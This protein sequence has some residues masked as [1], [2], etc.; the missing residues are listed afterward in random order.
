M[1]WSRKRIAVGLVA[2]I[3][4][5]LLALNVTGI[6]P[7]PNG[8]LGNHQ[9]AV[10]DG[11]GASTLNYEPQTTAIYLTA[12]VENTGP[13]PA[14]V[15]RV[16]PTGVTVPG[17]VEVVGS[18]PFNS[19]DPS[20]RLSDGMDG[21]MLGVQPDPGPRWGRPQPVTGVRVDPKGLAQYQGRA[22]LVRI[23]PD[24]TQATAVLRFDVEYTVGPFHFLTTAWGPI[25][26]TVVMCP[27]DRPIGGANGCEA[28]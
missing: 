5:T 6:A 26:T 27:R 15:V 18:L 12:L 14:T 13:L 21:V 8:P 20:E 28:G 11:G 2:L 3:V 24:P 17:S 19:D 9:P 10:R 16:T 23:T 7:I 4:V 25:G 22:F 1:K